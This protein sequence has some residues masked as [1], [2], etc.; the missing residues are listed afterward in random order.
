M[1]KLLLFLALFAFPFLVF[2]RGFYHHRQPTP[3]PVVPPPAATSSLPFGFFMPPAGVPSQWTMEFTDGAF[4]SGTGNLVIFLEPPYTDA[5]IL[6]GDFDSQLKSLGLAA[7]SHAGQVMMPLNEEVNC[8]NTDPW[9][10]AYKGNT[11]ASVIAAFQHEE[12][13]LKASDPKIIFAYSVN[14]ASCYGEG[15]LTDYYPGASY[16]SVI[17]LDGFDFG[18]QTWAQ[19]FDSAIT[20]LQTLKAPIWITSEGVVNTD[21][22]SQFTTDTFA[23][24]QRYG[25]AGV[26]YFN[27]QQFVLGSAALSTLKGLE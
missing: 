10:G 20:Q 12:K 25:L 19:V 2:A 15:G 21:N 26:M 8:D 3:P 1:K 9:G 24:A 22:Q 18:G 13:V 11:T 16:A 5:Q 23:G 6:A 4:P 7:S 14:N 27:Y 17:A